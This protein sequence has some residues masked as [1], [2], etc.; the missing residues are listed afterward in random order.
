LRTTRERATIVGEDG[1]KAMTIYLVWTSYEDIEAAFFKEEDAERWVD[2]YLRKHPI[3][4]GY[5]P[6]DRADFSIMDIEVK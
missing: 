1:V 3:Y 6:R 2:D 4:G 5:R